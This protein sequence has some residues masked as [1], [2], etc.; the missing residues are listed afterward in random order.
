M[1][2]YTA[3]H[4]QTLIGELI[5]KALAMSLASPEVIVTKR[6][7]LRCPH[8]RH[9]GGGWV[10]LDLADRWNC[11]DAS[12]ADRGANPVPG[13]V[14]SVS[15]GDPDFGT[16]AWACGECEG[17]VRIPDGVDVTWN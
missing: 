14:L 17:L 11:A 4:I 16:L 12:R 9:A 3:T 1:T 5:G 13:P 10:E 6:G 2:T 8:C 7:K 15:Q